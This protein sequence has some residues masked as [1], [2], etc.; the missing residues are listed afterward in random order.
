MTIARRLRAFPAAAL[1]LA[2]SLLA[3]TSAAYAHTALVSASPA[4][5]STVTEQPGQVVLTFNE[6]VQEQFA[7]V[8]VADASG[9]S[10]QTGEPQASGATVTQAVGELPDGTYTV[11]FRVVSADGHPV[12]GSYRFSVA[13]ATTVSAP[14]TTDSPSSTAPAAAP[15]APPADTSDP[16]PSEPSTPV[17]GDTEGDDRDGG[18]DAG[19]GAGAISALAVAAV[20]VIAGLGY[21]A[22]GGRRRAVGDV[23]ADETTEGSGA[24]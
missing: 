22:T 16:V 9:S 19:L 13:A 7:Q 12:T 17:A 20:A 14:S 8:A 18:A 15:A 23:E 10:Y 21:L 11:S 24:P 6:A 4:D 3:Y 5:G 1:V 2:L